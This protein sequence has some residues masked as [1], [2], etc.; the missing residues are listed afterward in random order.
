MSHSVVVCYGDEDKELF[1]ALQH[2]LEVLRRE[3]IVDALI[4]GA[5]HHS[6]SPYP[7]LQ[8]DLNNADAVVLLLSAGLVTHE[9]LRREMPG[10]L[11][12]QRLGEL[13]IIAIPTGNVSLSGT[14]FAPLRVRHLV[15]GWSNP[16][17]FLHSIT[18][19]IREHLAPSR[20]E[21][22]LLL[23]LENFT[24]FEQVSLR[25]SSS[26]NVFIG[27]NGT[28]KSHVLKLIYALMKAREDRILEFP[29]VAQVPLDVIKK[30]RGVFKPDDG[31][32]ER[33]IRRD[34]E[35]QVSTCMLEKER[36][37]PFRLVITAVRTVSSE[38]DH[39]ADSHAL[40]IPSRE[41]LAMY[42][43]F[44]RAYERRELSFDETY[45]DLCKELSAAPLREKDETGLA[46]VLS[47]LEQVL[48][49]TVKLSG[50]RFYVQSRL[51]EI[52]AHLVAEGMRKI[53]VLAALISNGALTRNSLLFWDEPEANLNPKLV[54]VIARILRQLAKAGVQIF[55][56]THDYLLIRELSL[57]AEY[58]LERSGFI[59]Y[60]S[61][62]RLEAEGPVL[63]ESD[64]TLAALEHNPIMEAFAAHDQRE[65]DLFYS[66]GPLGGQA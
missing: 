34:A 49:G 55:M 43:G 63:V 62:Y 44:T 5:I 21:R 54:V 2:Y 35:E 56:A 19:A 25:F 48:G 10:M 18:L 53:A 58:E 16:D 46:H 24:V 66:P 30:L 59:R 14:V 51:G 20:S 8:A 29:D 6:S 52:E 17:P 36:G 60:V 45:Y 57:A 50:N 27:V 42:E 65:Q 23:T 7:G 12:R 3:G 39:V 38:G 26:L 1:K 41:V 28:G 37:T 22:V 31:R 61:F 40:F 9:V 15:T 4:D 32:L 11:E 33:L 47:E 64:E 13:Y